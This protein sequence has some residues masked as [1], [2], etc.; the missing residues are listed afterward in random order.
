MNFFISIAV[1]CFIFILFSLILII[2][3]AKIGGMN[4]VFKKLSILFYVLTFIAIFLYY[5]YSNDG[6]NLL[7]LPILFLVSPMIIYYEMKISRFFIDVQSCPA[8][9]E[10][11]SVFVAIYYSLPFFVLTCII[12]GIIFYYRK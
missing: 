10:I 5:N 11:L 12:S 7:T 6:I 8:G 4:N 9:Y 3:Y 2:F 1:C